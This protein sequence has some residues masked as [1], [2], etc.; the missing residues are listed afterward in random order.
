MTLQTLSDGLNHVSIS[1]IVSEHLLLLLHNLS[2]LN[3]VRT[4]FYLKESHK[5]LYMSHP[6]SLHIIS[7]M[8]PHSQNMPILRNSCM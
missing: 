7:V 5:I 2:T 4:Q 6:M 1:T 8:I 3:T